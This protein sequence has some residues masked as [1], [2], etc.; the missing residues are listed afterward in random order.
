MANVTV[1]RKTSILDQIEQIRSRV[2]QRAYELFRRRG[3]GSDPT[4]DWLA[5]EQEL[6]W[7]PA[8]ELREKDGVFTVVAAVPGVDAKDVSVDV[9]P[10]GVVIKASA[11]TRRSSTEGQIHH[12][13]FTSAD[14]FRSVQ[15]P[16]AVDPARAKAD[17]RNGILTVTAP[18]VPA[19]KRVNIKAA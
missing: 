7:K 6:L 11:T 16:G 2:E 5:A 4:A 12:S 8:V 17:Y 19:A 1:T 9:S 15:F 13:E 18:A 10:E 14:L 3:G